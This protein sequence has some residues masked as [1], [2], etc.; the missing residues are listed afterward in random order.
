[1][2]EVGFEFAVGPV[3]DADAGVPL[4][5]GAAFGCL[6]AAAVADGITGEFDRVA[7]AVAD[8]LLLFLL[9]GMVAVGDEE[10]EPT[11]EPDVLHVG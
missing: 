11:L 9:E 5:I 7:A 8:L 2:Q 6:A 1:M 4:G 3:V 10:D